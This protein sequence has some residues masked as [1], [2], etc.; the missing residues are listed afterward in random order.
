M[1]KKWLMSSNN[2]FHLE[3]SLEFD[4]LDSEMIQPMRKLGDYQTMVIKND[5]E[6]SG[7]WS[8]DGLVMNDHENG[9][10]FLMD[11]KLKIDSTDGS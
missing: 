10:T 3:H 11:W 5:H 8:G 2:Q 6:W 1:P 9:Q 4:N 7:E